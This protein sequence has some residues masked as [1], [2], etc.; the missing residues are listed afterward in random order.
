MD[1]ASEVS[2]SCSAQFSDLPLELV[3]KIWQYALPSSSMVAFTH[4]SAGQGT[5]VS[6][7]ATRIAQIC[8]ASRGYISRDHRRI[9][10]FTA[11]NLSKFAW[12]DFE[13]AF[14]YLGQNWRY[15]L[16]DFQQIENDWPCSAVRYFV[17][18]PCGNLEIDSLCKA[19]SEYPA[20]KRLIILTPRVGVLTTGPRSQSLA[21]IGHLQRLQVVLQEDMMEG[22]SI[23][24]NSHN[25][26]LRERFSG[27]L[28][29]RGR[30][31]DWQVPTLRVL[32]S[33]II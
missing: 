10:F 24:E 15:T 19:L 3:F 5:L 31:S 28:T 14:V 8:K 12:I 1:K 17:M 27:S 32:V 6:S 29:L 21:S 25:T 16:R 11:L 33:N 7:E 30:L 26:Y 13:R 23:P 9:R 22:S 4:I 20:L 18:G 2:S